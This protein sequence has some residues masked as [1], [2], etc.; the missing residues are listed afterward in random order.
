MRLV[1]AGTPEVAVVSLEKVLSSRHEVLAVVTRPDA[2]A[3]RGHRVTPSP[4]SRSTSAA[5][6]GTDP[7]C[8]GPGWRTVERGALIQPKRLP[9]VES[10]ALASD[11]A[12]SHIVR[13]AS[14]AA[15]SP[16]RS[17]LHL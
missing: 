8:T 10:V 11:G 6:S 9:W 5:G 12:W 13:T 3:G 1:F 14:R 7:P 17:A 4:V 16:S 2:V 15:R